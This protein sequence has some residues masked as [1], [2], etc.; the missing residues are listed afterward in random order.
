[1]AMRRVAAALRHTECV[2]PSACRVRPACALCTLYRPLTRP[3]NTTTRQYV[4]NLAGEIAHE[5]ARRE[6]ADGA[7]FARVPALPPRPP[8]APVHAGEAAHIDDLLPLVRAI[9]PFHMRH[10]AEPEAVDLLVEIERLDLLL[11]HV[12]AGNYAR[13]ALYL[14][15]CASYLPEPDDATVLRVAHSIYQKVGRL[16][17]ALRCALK[18]A[19]SGSDLVAATWQAANDVQVRRQL[20]YMLAR[21]GVPLDLDDGP[22]AV[23][24]DTDAL[25]EILSNAKLSE[26]YLALARDLDVME[27]KTPEDIYKTH[28]VEGRAP[29]GAAAVDSARANLAS[30]FV[31]AFVNAGFGADKLLTKA[32]EGGSDVS[33]IYKNKDHGKM[34]AA[35]SLGSVLLWDVEGGLPQ[36]DKCVVWCAHEST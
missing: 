10:N 23:S 5:H 4:R 2:N 34:A 35:A 21:A 16:P 15:S 25:K 7:L 26:H 17:E 32:E 36:I 13:T 19:A 31:N 8:H 1:M 3:P 27:A 11:E 28:L 12:D 20:A 14:V 24:D 22:C 29:A 30:T 33:W 9:V 6:E 18:L